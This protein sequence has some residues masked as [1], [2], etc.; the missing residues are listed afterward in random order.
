MGGDVVFGEGGE[1][2][3]WDVVLELQMWVY[4]VEDGGEDGEGD[5]NG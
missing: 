4:D 5:D 1:V 3:V 2:W